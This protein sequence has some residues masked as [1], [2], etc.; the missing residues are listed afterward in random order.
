MPLVEP[1][2]EGTSLSS[3]QGI[4]LCRLHWVGLT[5]SVAQATLKLSVLLHPLP[6]HQLGLQVCATILGSYRV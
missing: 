4:S 3:T 1:A 5:S 2:E 6:F